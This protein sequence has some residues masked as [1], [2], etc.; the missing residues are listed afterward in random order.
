MT[1]SEKYTVDDI[2]K[3]VRP[4]LFKYSANG[5]VLFG[6]YANGQATNE[7]DIDIMVI[8]GKDFDPTDIFC[9]ADE[10][11]DV[12]GKMSMFMRKEK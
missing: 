12:S 5:A 4:L 7:S 11:Y 8:G 6:S 9:I 2:K 3:F 10:L 1:N